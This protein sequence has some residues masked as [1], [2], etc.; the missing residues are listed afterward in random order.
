MKITQINV[1]YRHIFSDRHIFTF[2][3]CDNIVLTV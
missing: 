3:V 2:D 1:Y